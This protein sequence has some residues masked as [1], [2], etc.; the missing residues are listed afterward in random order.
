MVGEVCNGGSVTRMSLFSRQLTQGHL[1]CQAFSRYIQCNIEFA[2]ANGDM[3]RVE[4]RD[5]AWVVPHFQGAV[6]Y[7]GVGGAVLRAG[8]QRGLEA[9]EPLIKGLRF[10]DAVVTDAGQ[11]NV[12]KLIQVVSVGS[13]TDEEFGVVKRTVKRALEVAEDA[14]IKT[15]V[16]PALG[17]GII[18][19]LTATQSAHAM[20]SAIREHQGTN[21]KQ[22]M[23]VV[24]R[25]ETAYQEFI[26]VY[27]H[28]TEVVSTVGEK[29]LNFG[30]WAVG[31]TLDW[32]AKDVITLSP[33]AAKEIGA[34]EIARLLEK[35]HL[36]EKLDAF[37]EVIGQMAA[38]DAARIRTT[39][40][41]DSI[42]ETLRQ[43]YPKIEKDAFN[44]LLG[45]ANQIAQQYV[46]CFASK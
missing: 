21:I 2:I 3:T 35:H 26:R 46:A 14:G 45:A 39:L 34:G 40:S 20:L 12:G 37:A 1:F 28:P 22:I 44:L 10:G 4:G 18:G 7:G 15:I 5:V 9:L 30:V 42:A 11:A 25:N 8:G 31:M 36:P 32:H 13:K 29:E 19:R 6:S 41:T 43:K 23:V 33:D 24:Y 16:F 27:N 38:E 17:T